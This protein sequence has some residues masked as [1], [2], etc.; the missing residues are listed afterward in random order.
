MQRIGTWLFCS[1]LALLPPGSARAET[2]EKVIPREHPLFNAP[3]AHLTVGR[4]FDQALE[5]VGLAREERLRRALRATWRP[6]E[7]C[8]AS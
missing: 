5:D 4:D 8:T 3:E 1:V 2:L 6:S 7:I